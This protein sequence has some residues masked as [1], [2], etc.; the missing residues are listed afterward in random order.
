MPVATRGTRTAG[1]LSEPVGDSSELCT[2][3]RRHAW[4]VGRPRRSAGPFLS[5]FRNAK[6]LSQN[7]LLGKLSSASIMQFSH[8]N[9][10]LCLKRN[11]KKLRL[12]CFC[13]TTSPS[14]GSVMGFGRLPCLGNSRSDSSSRWQLPP[15][16]QAHCGHLQTAHPGFQRRL[17]TREL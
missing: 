5:G 7:C 8:Q 13:A 14:C 1:P 15:G 12:K 3:G 2:C 4:A 16:D 17:R 11:K 9:Y 6:R 10:R